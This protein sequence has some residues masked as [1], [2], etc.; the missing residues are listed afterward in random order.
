M[1]RLRLTSTLYRIARLTRTLEVLASGDPARILRR[2]VKILLGRHVVSRLWLRPG[3]RTSR[4]PGN[5]R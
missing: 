4:T 5:T 2:L 1:R 3:K